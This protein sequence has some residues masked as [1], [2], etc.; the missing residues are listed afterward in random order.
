MYAS[1]KS[2]QV[3][4]VTAIFFALFLS[5]APIQVDLVHL[6]IHWSRV[7]AADTHSS[8]HSGGYRGGNKDHGHEESDSSHDGKKG[9]V[10]NRSPSQAVEKDVLRGHGRDSRPVWAGGGIPEIELGRL[11]VSRAPSFVLDRALAEAQVELANNP[12]ASV[13]SPLANLA[14]YRETLKVSE[15]N[16]EQIEAA[17]RY[18]GTAADKNT[19]ISDETVEA[20]NIILGTG[21]NLSNSQVNS[22]AQKADAIRAEILAAHDSAQEKNIEAGHS[23]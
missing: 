12:S 15:L 8:G 6:N 11:N 1:L 23:N 13:H 7:L 2:R 14:M 20:V 5:L 3:R 19:A 10:S 22:L 4:I 17:A 9:H 21:L 16:E 18:L